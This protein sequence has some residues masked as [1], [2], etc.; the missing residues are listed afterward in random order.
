[1]FLFKNLD[2]FTAAVK[3]FEKRGLK[4]CESR[5]R[6]RHTCSPTCDTG[7]DKL[8]KYTKKQKYITLPAGRQVASVRD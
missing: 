6:N 4:V 1:V 3:T 5:K 7:K 8:T 2:V